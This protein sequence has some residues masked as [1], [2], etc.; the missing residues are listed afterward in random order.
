MRT[1]RI[2]ARKLHLP[3]WWEHRTQEMLA[4]LEPIHA[5]EITRSVQA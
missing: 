3:P 4:Q 2:W 1:R 5:P